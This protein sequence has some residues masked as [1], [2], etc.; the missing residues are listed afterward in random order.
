MCMG[1]LPAVNVLYERP[2]LMEARGG[3]FSRTGVT[4]GCEQSHRHW[5]QNSN[6]EQNC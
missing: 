5:K 2:G 3:N 4:G 6:P 1:V